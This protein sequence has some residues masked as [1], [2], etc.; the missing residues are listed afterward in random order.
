MSTIDTV[1]S[2]R[3]MAAILSYEGSKTT[4]SMLMRYARMLEAVNRPVTDKEADKSSIAMCAVFEQTPLLDNY[5]RRRMKSALEAH[6]SALREE[7]GK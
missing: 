7:V 6:M 2:V 5:S 4:V 1:E 3:D